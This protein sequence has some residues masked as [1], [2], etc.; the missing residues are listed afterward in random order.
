M[1][2][3]IKDEFFYLCSSDDEVDPCL[4]AF[5][6]KSTGSLWGGDGALLVPGGRAWMVNSPLLTTRLPLTTSRLMGASCSSL[7]LE[8]L[9]YAG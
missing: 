2:E 9:A 7:E 8:V 1:W 3:F 6:E 4:T 5:F